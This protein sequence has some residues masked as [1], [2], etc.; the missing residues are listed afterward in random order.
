MVL[1]R[2]PL[3]G[4]RR[5]AAMAVAR[6]ADDFE[7]AQ[8]AFAEA[9][10]LDVMVEA[11]ASEP[12]EVRLATVAL[13]ALVRSHPDNA[14]VI[15]T[16]GCMDTLLRQ[17]RSCTKAERAEAARAI[18]NLAEVNA[19]ADELLQKLGAFVAVRRELDML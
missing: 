11:L 4:E 15:V 3:A 8:T 2:S 5:N 9:G 16:A 10:A 6:I 13:A 18:A 12:A 1:L 7:P 14:A 19:E 17:L